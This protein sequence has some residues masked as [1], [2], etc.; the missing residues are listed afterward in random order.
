MPMDTLMYISGKITY[1][2]YLDEEISNIN[3]IIL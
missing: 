1:K 3:S 2:K